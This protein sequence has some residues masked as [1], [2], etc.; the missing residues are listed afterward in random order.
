MKALYRPAQLIAVL[1][2]LS[3]CSLSAAPTATPTETPTIP[4]TAT[5]TPAP[6]LTVPPTLTPTITPTPTA[7][8]EP[9]ATPTA[10]S[11][12]YPT[13]PPQSTVGFS[14]DKFTRVTID[15]PVID[16]IGR[17]W[18][19]FININDKPSTVVPGTPSA[20]SGLETVY[21]VAP[22]GGQPIK[23]IDLPATTDKRL[24]W[25]RNGAYLAYFVEGGAGSGGLYLLDLR[26]G[27]ST[28][29]FDIPDLNPR[30]ILS[31]PIW[32]PD[33]SQ[34][35]ITL[36][37]AY[38]VDIFSVTADGSQFRNLTQ[39]GAF[40]F[41]PAW[42]P[43]GQYLAFVSDRKQCPNW[44]PNEPGSCY[45]PDAA[46]PDGGNLYVIEIASGDIR[47]VSD[48]WVN[49]PPHW[50]SASRLAFTSGKPGDL[51]AGSTLWWADLRGGSPRRITDEDPAGRLVLRDVWSADGR[52]VAYQEA[53]S[54]THIVIRDDMGKEISRSSSLNF[55]RYAL[56]AA[57]SPDGKRLVIGGHNSQC[58]YGMIVTDETLKVPANIPPNPGVCDPVWSP[59]GKY[60][61]FGGVTQSS[62]GTDGRF[63]VYIAEATGF[64]T[65]NMTGRMG[66]QVR[67]LGWVGRP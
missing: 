48:A 56:S 31:E 47:L 35:T 64:G 39:S 44:I 19:S 37:T 45:K 42:S 50:I 15:K 2:A 6:T 30:S 61:A 54:I 27:V 63:D 51:T 33:S 57:W 28:R 32:S 55:P 22:T 49:A 1:I 34:L 52:R 5:Q 13:V 10:S 17:L 66:G 36:A 41:W 58:P 21:L 65:R 16:G 53:E 8:L 12:P 25:S 24:Y 26:V 18:L 4:A 62:S 23:V 20:A 38:D 59:D 46:I 43:D 60:I 3:A 67:M 14:G 40:D 29:L 11:T 7:T 9:S